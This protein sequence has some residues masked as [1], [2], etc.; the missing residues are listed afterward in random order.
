M[1]EGMSSNLIQVR[2]VGV[3][4]SLS[5]QTKI[6]QDVVLSMT[7]NPRTVSTASAISCLIRT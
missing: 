1:V 2:G 4:S 7:P 5:K 6:L 3:F